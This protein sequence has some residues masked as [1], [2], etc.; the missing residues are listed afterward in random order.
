MVS[1]YPSEPGGSIPHTRP[2][3]DPQSQAP[4][5]Q[6]R[7]IRGYNPLQEGAVPTVREN[8]GEDQVRTIGYLMAPL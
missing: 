4:P 7:A 2:H 3:G 1:L 6:N 5:V 8:G